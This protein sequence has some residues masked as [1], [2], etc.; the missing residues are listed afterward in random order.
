LLTCRHAPL[1]LP[2]ALA[3]EVLGRY[4][5]THRAYHDAAHIA[6][7]LGWFDEV[8]EEPGL[9]WRAPREVFV[10]ILFHDVVYVPGAKDNEARS[11]ELARAHATA[12]GVDGDRVAQLIELTARHGG[13]APA[14]VAGDLDAALFLDCDMAI[15]GAA[16]AAFDAYCDDIR[17]E[18]AA[19]PEAA[20]RA[21]RGA[22]LAGLLAR[23]R[24]FLSDFFH[25]RLDAAARANLARAIARLAAP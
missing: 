6:E 9:G 12:L 2:A 25:A 19:V 7:V 17:F 24:I 3:V 10:A 8:A 18:Y 16:P 20:Y 14:D 4:G 23:P 5:E 13:L 21:G 1:A 22:F 15:V 11:A